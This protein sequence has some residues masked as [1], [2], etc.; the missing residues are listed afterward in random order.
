MVNLNERQGVFTISLRDAE[1]A[2]ARD[3][4]NTMT[5]IYI[6]QIVEEVEEFL[7]V[8]AND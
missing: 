1:P 3:F 6:E 4:V 8:D 5:R 2:F 7:G